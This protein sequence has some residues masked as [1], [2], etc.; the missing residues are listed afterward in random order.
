MSGPLLAAEEELVVA[1]DRIQGNI[2]PGF[3]ADHQAF[4][5][6]RFADAAAARAWIGALLPHVTPGTAV[7]EHRQRARELPDAQPAPDPPWVNVAFTYPLLQLAGFAA[8]FNDIAFKLGIERRRARLN[9]D[10][11][12]HASW[13]VGGGAPV[14]ALLIVAAASAEAAA[15]CADALSA[16][17]A[18]VYA[19]AGATLR[20]RGDEHFGFR[21]GVSQPSVFGRAATGE[22]LS[23][24]DWAEPPAGGLLTA[25]PG[26]PLIWPGQFVFGYP[27]QGRGSQRIPGEPVHAGSG[28]RAL[29]DDGAYLVL[30]R[31]RQDVALFHAVCA[32]RAEELAAGPWPG[33]TRERLEALVVGR[34]PS[35][36]PVDARAAA[37][38][39][40]DAEAPP[41]AFDFSDDPDGLVCPFGAHIRKVNPRAG[42]S[43]VVPPEQRMF[44]RRGIPYGAEPADPMIDDG[45]DR[46]LIFVS[47][48]TSIDHQFE[49]VVDDWMNDGDRPS[50]SGGGQDLLI[51]QE[52]RDPRRMT[53][54]RDGAEI[55]LQ[56]AD[57]WVVPTGGVYA[58]APS[59]PAL[60]QLAHG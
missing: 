38:P 31:L 23:R 21:D 50:R 60:E 22:P 54:Y 17:A 34:W 26:S 1:T 37:D 45:A 20:R 24:R 9:D 32:A 48:Q 3:K 33:M 28:G 25:R 10:P 6:L 43:D 40:A 49:D 8:E 47:Y 13:M 18:V 27:G 7:A 51:G 58:F 46:G 29:T 59:L 53:L 12:L 11:A 36:A 16:G 4:R 19:D 39:G 2:L 41:N 30:R 35:G 14:H 5:G 52:L 44:L 42:Q 56:V 55:P 15:A 57:R